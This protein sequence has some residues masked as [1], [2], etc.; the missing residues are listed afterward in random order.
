ML[1]SLSMGALCFG[2]V[3][4]FH[5]FDI[6]PLGLCLHWL[7][8]RICSFGGFVYAFKHPMSPLVPS[9]TYA[10]PGVNF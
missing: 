3:F 5:Y 6:L 7:S 2:G 4:I 1:F 10:V 8:H 9:G